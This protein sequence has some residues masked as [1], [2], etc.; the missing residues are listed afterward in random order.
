MVFSITRAGIVDSVALSRWR[1]YDVDQFG[2]IANG[3]LP[4]EHAE[5]FLQ[6]DS[7]LNL[8][9]FSP[10]TQMSIICASMMFAS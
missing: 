9:A 6:S 3:G 2:E 4:N 1:I 5:K 10:P 8:D 7:F